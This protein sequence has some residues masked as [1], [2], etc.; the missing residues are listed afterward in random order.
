L[1][2]NRKEAMDWGGDWRQRRQRGNKGRIGDLREK[3]MEPPNP[4]SPLK[5]SHQGGDFW[6]DNRQP[7]G[8]PP[9]PTP[10]FSAC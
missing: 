7:P 5:A 4:D 9:H 8:T 2:N 3:P 1:K 10:L 6:W